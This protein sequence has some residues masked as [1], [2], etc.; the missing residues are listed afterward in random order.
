MIAS[1]I[2][3]TAFYDL[4][5]VP[6]GETPPTA[7]TAIGL[8]ELNAMLKLLIAEGL[9]LNALTEDTLTLTAGKASYTISSVVGSDFVT[10][11]PTSVHS[12]FIR[13]SSEDYIVEVYNSLNKYND[14]A[15]KTTSGI[16]SE[17][18]YNPTFD[19]GIFYLYPVPAGA[20]SLYLT[21]V[22]QIAAYTAATETIVLPGE[23]ELML[24][25]NLAK[26]LMPKFGKYDANIIA[27]ADNAKETI[28]NNNSKI[29]LKECIFDKSITY[30]L[31]R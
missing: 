15:V 14:Y 3:N 4:G 17:L 10:I 21:S 9:M 8:S 18:F 12:A 13:I 29:Y 20:Y 16:P 27:M 6:I 11:R 24:S 5:V 31:C 26:Y 2:I 25:K 28:M 7:F 22:K 23:Y 30:H 19:K 1:D